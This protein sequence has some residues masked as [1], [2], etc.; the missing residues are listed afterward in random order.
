[1]PPKLGLAYQKYEKEKTPSKVLTSFVEWGRR[2][3]TP[4]DT[5]IGNI[6]EKL[7]ERMARFEYGVMNS[8]IVQQARPV[9]IQLSEK[10]KDKRETDDYRILDIAL[11]NGDAEVVNFYAE[12]LG[13]SDDLVEVRKILDR[14]HK[15]A[16]NLGIDIKY[17]ENYFP[18]TVNDSV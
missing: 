7:R 9:M 4:L 12:K 16:S 17:L 6:S 1:M 5:A 15:E 8:E 14:I 2:S 11:K 18:R 3:F 13:I 10:I